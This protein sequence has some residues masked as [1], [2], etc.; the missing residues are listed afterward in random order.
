MTVKELKEIASKYSHAL[1]FFIKIFV[2]KVGLFVVNIA[3][4]LAKFTMA[5]PAISFLPSLKLSFR[6][7][8]KAMPFFLQILDLFHVSRA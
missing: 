8:P 2:T 3:K 4:E 6:Y 5:L 1:V 7:P